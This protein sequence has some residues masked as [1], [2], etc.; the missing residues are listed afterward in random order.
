[1]EKIAVKVGSISYAIK[2]KG[3]LQNE[4][5]KV[6]MTRDLNPNKGEG[7]G[8]SL[9]IEGSSKEA[10]KLLKKSGIRIYGVSKNAIDFL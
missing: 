8:Y 3:L 4:G 9:C 10:L 1:M 2:G 6:Y 7:C 5:F